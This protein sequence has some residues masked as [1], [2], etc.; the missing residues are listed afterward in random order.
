MRVVLACVAVICLFDLDVGK[1]GVV[2]EPGF[3]SACS[4]NELARLA[5]ATYLVYDRFES[6]ILR[7]L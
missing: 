4:I 3:A 7:T 2:E 6:D 1:D 5:S